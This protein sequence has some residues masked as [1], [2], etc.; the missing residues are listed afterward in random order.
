MADTIT[1]TVTHEQILVLVRG[2]KAVDATIAAAGK[3]SDAVTLRAA[4]QM[5][6]ALADVSH[7]AKF[8]A[9]VRHG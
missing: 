8:G 5:L 2:A 7:T 1:V 9:E 3:E 4:G 6:A